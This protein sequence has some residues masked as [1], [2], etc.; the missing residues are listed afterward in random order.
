MGGQGNTPR[1]PISLVVIARNEE[2]KLP[3]CL[4]SCRPYVSEILVGDM[5]SSDRTAEIARSFGA[6]VY[7]VPEVGFVEPARQSITEKVTQPWTLVLDADERMTP[8]LFSRVAQWI[9]DDQIVGVELPWRNILFGRWLRHSG[10]WPETHLRLYRTACGTWSRYVHSEVEVSGCVL[11][12]PLDNEAAVVH[13]N[14]DTVAQW[15]EKANRYTTQELDAPRNRD[16]PF[17]HR[18]LILVP[19]RNFLTR[20]FARRGFRDR[21]QGLWVAMLMAVY[22][23]QL[24]LKRWER[25]VNSP[26][27]DQG[28]PPPDNPLPPPPDPR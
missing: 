23:F 28:P 5:G 17:R 26:G 11:R 12:A 4:A 14:Y 21:R 15:F 7:A 22:G 25:T 8:A 1:L 16:R 6:D 20:Y 24:E 18:D 2:E 9:E 3:G 10:Y 19:A 27:R 13:L